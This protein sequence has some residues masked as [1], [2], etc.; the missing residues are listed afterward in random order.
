ML[1]DLL[2]CK[3]FNIQHHFKKKKNK[4]KNENN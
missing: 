4:N 3:L 2:K 1:D